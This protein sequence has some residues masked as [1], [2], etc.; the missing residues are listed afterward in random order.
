MAYSRPEPLRAEHRLEGFRSGEDSLDTWLLSYARTAEGSGSA[1]VFVTAADGTTVAGFYALSAGTVEPADATSRLRKG[2]PGHRSVPVVVLGRL[3]VA[4]EHQ[5][6]GLGRSLLQDALVRVAGAAE[7]V[8]I[9][10]LVVHALNDDVRGWY[11]H[12]GFE[13]SP[14]DPL[15]LILLI[16]DLRKLLDQGGP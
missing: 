11:L 16:K 10:A 13:P 6:K 14:T 3:A 9:R 15:H 8:G 5:G 7:S 12:Y 1:R 4:A 2:Q